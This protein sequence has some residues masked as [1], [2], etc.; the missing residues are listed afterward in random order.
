MTKEIIE[1]ILQLLGRVDLKGAEVAGFNQIVKALTDERAK[2]MDL[3]TIEI[4]TEQ[5]EKKE[6]KK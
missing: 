3:G 1:G 2:L 6:D 5:P 4:P